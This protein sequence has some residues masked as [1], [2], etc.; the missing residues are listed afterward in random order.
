MKLRLKPFKI[1]SIL[2]QLAKVKKREREK[3]QKA[4]FTHLTPFH[5]SEVLNLT[6]QLHG[7]MQVSGLQPH[8]LN[9]LQL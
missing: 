2:R 6:A 3:R 5:L 7:T 8:I 1:C 4:N 9:S